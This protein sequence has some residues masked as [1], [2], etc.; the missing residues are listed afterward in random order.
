MPSLKKKNVTVDSKSMN[1]AFRY[2]GY[3][4]ILYSRNKIPLPKY[5]FKMATS[6]E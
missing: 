6:T 5:D 1:K 3:K 4:H 2:L